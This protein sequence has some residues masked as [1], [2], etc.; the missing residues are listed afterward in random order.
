MHW[1]KATLSSRVGV[2]VALLQDDP[3]ILLQMLRFSMFQFSVTLGECVFYKWQISHACYFQ[4]RGVVIPIILVIIFASV[5]LLGIVIVPLY[6]LV[7]TTTHHDHDAKHPDRKPLVKKL[8][9]HKAVLK[10]DMILLKV[11]LGL[12]SHDEDKSTKKE[13]ETGWKAAKR[14]ENELV[15]GTLPFPCICLRCAHWATHRS[16]VSSAR[17]L[18][19]TETEGKML[20]AAKNFADLFEAR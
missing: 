16:P 1:K 10:A 12:G 7:S 14:K 19:H 8:A 2:A 20:S 3:K 13:G 18:G 6:S 11:S 4:A 15:S 5:C 17:A 9:T